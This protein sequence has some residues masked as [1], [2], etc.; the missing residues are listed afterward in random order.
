[1]C[2]ANGMKINISKTKAISFSRKTNPLVYD[3]MLCRSS[4]TRTDCIKDLDVLI[5]NK[6]H[7]HEHIN[8]IFSQC[9]MLLGLGLEE[10]YLD[11]SISQV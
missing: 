4:I 2:I 5:D 11:S 3:Y 7:F 8:H 9:I 10:I 1:M 6:L